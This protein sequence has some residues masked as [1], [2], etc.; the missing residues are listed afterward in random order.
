LGR[1]LRDEVYLKDEM[2]ETGDGDLGLRP[3][4]TY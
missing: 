1:W 4:I 2:L 3:R